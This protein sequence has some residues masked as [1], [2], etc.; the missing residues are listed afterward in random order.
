MKKSKPWMISCGL[1][2]LLVAGC[3]TIEVEH[4]TGPAA[5][6]A[7]GVLYALPTTVLRTSVKIDRQEKSGAPYA[8][9]AAIFVTDAK[10]V[11]AEAECTADE[12]LTFSLAQGATISTYGEPDPSQVFLVQFSGG[13]AI[14]QSLSMTWNE[15]GLLS[16][17]SATVTNRTMDIV[18]SGIKMA[19]SL[20]T[21]FAGGAAGA[22]VVR[23]TSCPNPSSTD[24][25]VLPIL[26][27]SHDAALNQLLVYHYCN[28][29]PATRSGWARADKDKKLLTAAISDYVRFVQPLTKARGDI[30]DGT[31]NSVDQASLLGK[32]ETELDAAITRYFTGKI[33]TKTWAGVLDSRDVKAGASL[34][35]TIPLL[36]LDP[37]KGI[38]LKSATI[39]PDAAPIP[40]DFLPSDCTSAT[41]EVSLNV[42]FYPDPSTQLFTKIT[43][44]NRGK[45]SFRYRIPAHV[46]ATLQ[47]GKGGSAGAAIISVAQLGTVVSLP[48]QRHSKS[49]TYELGFVEATGALKT[50]KLGT[51]GGFDSSTVDALSSSAGTVV[52][53]RNAAQKNQQDLAVLTQEDQLLQLRDDICTIKQKYGIACTVA[54]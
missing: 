8:R 23:V 35:L 13:G 11:C 27:Q 20:G 42:A 12:K 47:D 4:I 44:D 5:V 51:T 17:T 46:S 54:P 40:K 2:A 24:S 48:A 45:R 3:G 43:D 9:Y 52:D 39:P 22:V 53:A 49:L 38:C 10:P 34:P 26:Q 36:T 32:L 19:T 30:L 25:W 15:A 28:I 7:S 21:K 18:S 41:L 33:A 37:K 29:A 31:S 6:P 50:F 16:S 1:G 14:D